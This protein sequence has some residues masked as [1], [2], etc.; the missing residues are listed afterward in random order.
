M[1]SLILFY[2]F[3]YLINFSAQ[4]IIHVSH[5]SN[6]YGLIQIENTTASDDKT[7]KFWNSLTGILIKTITSTVQL[8]GLTAI[9]SSLSAVGSCS[10]PYDV[11]VRNIDTNTLMKSMSE[12]L[13]CVR[14]VL[15]LPSGALMTCSDDGT[16]KLWNM[17]TFTLIKTLSLSGVSIVRSL[18]WLN[19]GL[20]AAT[21]NNNIRVEYNI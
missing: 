5:T 3:F 1:P 8:Y 19:N 13:N 4:L 21:G 9:S 18:C 20:L 7:I 12:H 14:T 15:L 10:T 2:Y 11:Q 16:I 17:T 6:I